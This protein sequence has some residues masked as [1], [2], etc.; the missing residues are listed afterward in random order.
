MADEQ[1]ISP[2]RAASV[3]GYS[4]CIHHE[5]EF[6]WFMVFC[7]N[8]AGCRIT[9]RCAPRPFGVAGAEPPAL[10]L[11]CGQVVEPDLFYVAGSTDR[12]LEGE[13]LSVAEL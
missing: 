8:G 3:K 13:L 4:W 6:L 2:I 12:Q 10:N 1:H 11:A 9:R 5:T 7:K